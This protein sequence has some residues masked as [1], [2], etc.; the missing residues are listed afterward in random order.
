MND[1][2]IMEVKGNN[3]RLLVFENYVFFERKSFLGKVEAFFGGKNSNM[4]EKR[5]SMDQILSVEYSLASMMRNGY[6]SLAVIGEEKNMNGF[7]GAAKNPTSLIFFPGANSEA[8][9]CV[10]YIN[11][12]IREIK[13]H[14]WNRFK[15]ERVGS[16]K[17]STADEI[18]KYKALLD[19]G[20]ITPEEFE[21]K[22]KELLG[23]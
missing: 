4:P 23:F 16:T 19:D 15:E 6:I 18:R 7:F 3:G 21:R 12:R 11:A 13:S 5:V 2:L 14:Q 20:I 9:R 22:K 8:E 10:S 1:R 17:L